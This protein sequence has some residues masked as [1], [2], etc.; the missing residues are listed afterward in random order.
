MTWLSVI[1]VVR[2]DKAGFARSLTSLLEQNLRDWEL[3]VVDGSDDSQEIPDLL[4]SDNDSQSIHYMWHEPHGVYDAMNI[5]LHAAKGRWV[6]FLNAG[7]EFHTVD[8]L[9]RV[10]GSLMSKDDGWAFGPIEIIHRDGS[11]V[12]TPKWDYQRE[13]STFFSRGLF[14]AHQ[15]TFVKRELLADS[16]G[17]DLRYQVAADYAAFLKL[18]QMSDPVELPFTIATFR[19]GGLSTIQWKESLR[20]FNRARKEIL[21]P[22]GLRHVHQAFLAR[23]HFILMLIHREIRPWLTFR[24]PGRKQ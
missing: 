8:V 24:R 9:A 4:R 17:F 3:V 15:G 18:S 7:D 19:E 14:P 22:Q 10:H 23:R 2:N 16:G 12:V 6:Y 21:K 11:S 13:R 1:S 5:G 20:D